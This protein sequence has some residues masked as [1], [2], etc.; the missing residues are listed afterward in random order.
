[1]K[2]E[3]HDEVRSST[4]GSLNN[5]DGDAFTLTLE[6][7]DEARAM[8]FVRSPSAGATCMF[9][10]TTRDTFQERT[11][12]RLE[13]EAYSKLALKTM[14]S[15]VQKARSGQLQPTVEGRD[16]PSSDR[17]LHGQT[18]TRI[19]M[20]HRL[21]V[22][23]VGESSIV[24]AVSSPHRRESFE[25]AE[26]LLE[27]VKREVP[28]WKREVYAEGQRDLASGSQSTWKANF[29]TAA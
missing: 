11:V 8:K 24:I 2:M 13:Y 28:I 3:A 15:I 10:G 16:L 20:S 23:P 22:V 9:V 21:G 29:P 18:V 1:G 17:L 14:R 12:N 4:S 7:L 19:Y 27:Q 26:W 6:P 5:E 25:V